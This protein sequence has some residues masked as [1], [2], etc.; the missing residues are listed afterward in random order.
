MMLDDQLFLRP[1][2]LRHTEH[3]SVSIVETNHGE[4][5]QTYENVHVECLSVLSD[6]NHQQNVSKNF[7]KNIK[8]EILR[9]SIR[10]ESLCCVRTNRVADK[11]R[12]FA[13]LFCKSN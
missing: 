7:S 10:W 3:K 11:A 4:A 2:R 13:Q 8:Y 5:A 12:A 9:K 6:F 1:Q